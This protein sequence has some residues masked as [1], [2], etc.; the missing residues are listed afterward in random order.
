MNE[1]VSICLPVLNEIDV[2][3]EVLLEWLELT[4]RLPLGSKVIVE[5]GGSIDG[6]IQILQ[7]L[8][9][10]YPNLTVNY[11]SKPDG[12]G[13]A[14]KRLLAAP[15]TEWLFFTDADGQYV[16]EDFW[17]LWN[18]RENFDVVRGIK[19]G[20]Q[21]PL[22]RRVTSLIWNKAVSFLFNLPLIDINAAFVLA[23][24][25]VIKEVLPLVTRLQTLVTSELI[26]RIILAN[27]ELKNTYVR[28]RKRT[29]GKSR[30]VPTKKL[31]LIAVKQLKGLFLIKSDYRIK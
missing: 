26:I 15:D 27:Y 21:D 11:R 2:I 14:A 18:R 22:L 20:R 4:K 25:N 3:Q 23:R 28:H 31:P 19:M 17:I 29:G 24:T 10:K 7:K 13:N 5:D 30:G 9:S 8:E 16:P 6:T 12:F 1:S